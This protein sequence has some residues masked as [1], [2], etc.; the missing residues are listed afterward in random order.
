MIDTALIIHV[1]LGRD[2]LLEILSLSMY[3]LGIYVNNVLTLNTDI[4][5][6]FNILNVLYFVFFLLIFVNLFLSTP[7]FY[8]YKCSLK[9]YFV[10]NCCWCIEIQLPFICH[11]ISNLINSINNSIFTYTVFHIYYTAISSG[12]KQFFLT[13]Q[14]LYF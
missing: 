4:Y 14:Y 7:Y 5:L 2:G 6:A 9:F 3:E 1:N 10:A 11:Y 12:T 13:F 8:Y